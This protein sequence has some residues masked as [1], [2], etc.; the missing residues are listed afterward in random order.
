MVWNVKF[1]IIEKH[2]RSCLSR[3]NETLNG[4]TVKLIRKM[5]LY[6]KKKTRLCR[7]IHIN[8]KGI[9]NETYIENVNDPENFL[10]HR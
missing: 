2:L 4:N 1:D 10:S 3:T 8:L 9:C 6:S 5:K 7:H